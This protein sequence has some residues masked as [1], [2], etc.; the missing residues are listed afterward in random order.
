MVATRR[1]RSPSKERQEDIPNCATPRLQ[2]DQNR[3]SWNFNRWFYICRFWNRYQ[4]ISIPKRHIKFA[5]KTIYYS[6]IKRKEHISETVKLNKMIINYFVQVI[7]LL[8]FTFSIHFYLYLVLPGLK[9][10][11]KLGLYWPVV[12]TWQN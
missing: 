9:T 4:S 1:N 10:V 2:R 6:L 11:H 7:A 5:G 12:T 8:A 3:K